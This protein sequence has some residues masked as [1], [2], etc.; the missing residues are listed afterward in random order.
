[1]SVKDAIDKYSKRFANV[2]KTKKTKNQ[3]PEKAVEKE[4]VEYLRGAGFD[5][6]VVESKAVFSRGAGRYLR[7]QTEPGFS[8]LAG[9]TPC[10]G[11]AC[12]IELK[13]VGKRQNLS[14][15]QCDFLT[16]KIRL[17]AFAC[18]TDS[19]FHI[20]ETYRVWVM[21]LKQNSEEAKEFLLKLL[22]TKF[23]QDDANVFPW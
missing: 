5:I 8:D 1:M 20:A 12:F 22:P 19:V 7:G 4:V 21:L 16:R 2:K 13:A 23:Q 14:R 17:G 11:I 9:V 18:S 6:S 10:N 3:S 15:A